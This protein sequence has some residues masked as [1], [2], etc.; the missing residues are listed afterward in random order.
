M[1]HACHCFWKC[2]LRNPFWQGAESLAPATQKLHL[3]LQKWS[4]PR[5]FLTF[6]LRN[7]LRAT[8]A[9]TF[10]TTQ[11]PKVIREWCAY[12]CFVHFDFEMCFAP[13][14]RALFR[15][16]NFQSWSEREVFNFFTCKCASRHNGVHFFN[17]STSKS[18]PRPSVF[19]LW[20][21]IFHLSSGQMAPHPPL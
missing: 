15:R 13:Q 9:C 16:L 19:N 20:L 12:V 4:V 18:R 7:V 11:F 21:P 8:T 10:S 5:V 14:Q 1:S 2:K 6:W 17:I 3:N